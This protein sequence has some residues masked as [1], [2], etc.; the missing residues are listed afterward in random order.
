MKTRRPHQILMVVFDGVQLLDVTGPLEVYAAA[1]AHGGN[2]RIS[3]ASLD[4][5]P[6]R[7]TAGCNWCPTWR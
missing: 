2:Y 1:N 3:T 7:A 6:V 5:K 4:G